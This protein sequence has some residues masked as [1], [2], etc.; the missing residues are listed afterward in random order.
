MSRVFMC[1][2]SSK[3]GLALLLDC[4]SLIELHNKKK[5]D[6]PATDPE[7]TKE[8]EHQ[9]HTHTHTHTLEAKDGV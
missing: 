5:K 6:A 8:C 3:T 7:S 4:T 1:T 9:H 2:R